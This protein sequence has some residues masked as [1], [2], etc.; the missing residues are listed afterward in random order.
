[1]ASPAPDA[2]WCGSLPAGCPDTIVALPMQAAAINASTVDA[3]NRQRLVKRW[4]HA[5]TL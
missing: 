5:L 4:P 1:M 3:A 2:A